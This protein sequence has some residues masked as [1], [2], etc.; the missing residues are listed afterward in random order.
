MKVIISFV[1]FAVMAS[2]IYLYEVAT[3]PI[4]NIIFCSNQENAEK[5]KL[6]LTKLL[7]NEMKDYLLASN[8]DEKIIKAEVLYN[9]VIQVASKTGGL[10]FDNR[11][12]R[13]KKYGYSLR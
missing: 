2:S 5:F 1:V 12:K 3:K 11:E 13:Q 4:S 10:R 9:K 8:E 7:N 6:E